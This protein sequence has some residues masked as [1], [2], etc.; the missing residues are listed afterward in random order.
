M[1]TPLSTSLFLPSCRRHLQLGKHAWPPAHAQQHAGSKRAMQRLRW[2][3]SRRPQPVPTGL[4]QSVGA[5][6]SFRLGQ[7]WPPIA[8]AD[9][10]PDGDRFLSYGFDL[11]VCDGFMNLLIFA[12][13]FCSSHPDSDRSS[14][15]CSLAAEISLRRVLGPAPARRA[16]RATEPTRHRLSE[17][18]VVRGPRSRHGVLARHDTTNVSCLVGSCQF[19]SCLGVFV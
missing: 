4:Q 6:L 17:V 13:I 1:S 19:V 11:C 18:R 7:L 2:A 8:A 12:M 14:L 9:G 16:S 10:A 5:Q 15:S 3:A